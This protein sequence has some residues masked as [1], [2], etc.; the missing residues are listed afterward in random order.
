MNLCVSCN[1]LPVWKP[2]HY[3]GEFTFRFGGGGKIK[4]WDCIQSD[5][6]MTCHDAIH[7][8]NGKLKYWTRKRCSRYQLDLVV[9]TILRKIEQ[10]KWVIKDGQGIEALYSDG[11]T[12]DELA[13]LMEA[14][15]DKIIKGE[16]KICN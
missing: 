6:C 16:I 13:E 7:K 10:G 12:N 9:K 11:L 3:R 2:H 4:T 14:I 15:N 1:E 8:K 5:I